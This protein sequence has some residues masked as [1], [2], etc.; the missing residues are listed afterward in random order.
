MEKDILN[1]RYLTDYRKCNYSCECCIAGFG[2]T[3][4]RQP[5]N[6][7]P[8]LFKRIIKNFQTLPGLCKQD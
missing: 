6:W 3:H 7:N 4:P 5:D 8:F 2:T 1:I